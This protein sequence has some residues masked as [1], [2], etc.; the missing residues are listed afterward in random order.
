MKPLANDIGEIDESKLHLMSRP[1]SDAGKLQRICLE[2]LR[3]HRKDGYDGIPTNRRFLAY[4]LIQR[5]IIKKHN[6]KGKRRGDQNMHD[7]LTH[8]RAKGIVPWP[9]LNDESRVINFNPS[10][11][12]LSEW[13]TASV[14]YI[15]LHH[16]AAFAEPGAYKTVPMMMVVDSMT[17]RN[18]TASLDLEATPRLLIRLLSSDGV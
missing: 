11:N 13:A 7:A 12:S 4:E 10:W 17:K 8:L 3:E 16:P 14:K 2:L 15:C 5:A 18:M 6:E 1:D 9:W